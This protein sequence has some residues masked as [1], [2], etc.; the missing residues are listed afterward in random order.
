LNGSYSYSDWYW[1]KRPKGKRP[2]K[3][4]APDTKAD[5]AGA[6]G[7]GLQMPYAERLTCA[8]LFVDISGFKLS[9][10]LDVES[11]KFLNFKHF[12]NLKNFEIGLSINGFFQMDEI[13][14]YNGDILKFAGDALFAEWRID[15]TCSTDVQTQLEESVTLHRQ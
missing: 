8:L 7:C 6:R 5:M 12:L 4:L 2:D 15:S 9:T 10:L 3:G 14:A 13:T 11:L 1:D